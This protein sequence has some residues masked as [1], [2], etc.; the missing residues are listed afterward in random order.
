LGWNGGSREGGGD[1]EG[2]SLSRVNSF[3][4]GEQ[5]VEAAQRALGFVTDGQFRIT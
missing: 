5:E 2:H 4:P 3:E 1:H